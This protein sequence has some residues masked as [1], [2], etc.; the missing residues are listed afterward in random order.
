MVFDRR[1]LNL[2][3]DDGSSFVEPLPDANVTPAAAA[4]AATTAPQGRR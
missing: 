1:L 4:A 2:S 3:Q